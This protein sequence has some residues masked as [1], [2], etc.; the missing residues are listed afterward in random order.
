[1]ARWL[2]P[3]CSFAKRSCNKLKWDEKLSSVSLGYLRDVVKSLQL[4][5][6]VCGRWNVCLCS[7]CNVWCDASLLAVGI[8]LYV[9]EVCVED[10]SCLRS[11][12]LYTSPSP[13]D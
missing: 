3:A 7:S 12:L 4:V 13:R 10:Q 11:C 5:D 2:R 1:M 9:D 8:V 6:P